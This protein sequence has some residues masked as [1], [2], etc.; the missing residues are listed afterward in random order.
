[1][2]GR[3]GCIL[4]VEEDREFY[5][6]RGNNDRTSRVKNLLTMKV[7]M[8]NTTVLREAETGKHMECSDKVR[9]YGYN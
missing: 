8:R 7:I 4:C 6:E 5:N 2:S 1:M 9:T 3:K